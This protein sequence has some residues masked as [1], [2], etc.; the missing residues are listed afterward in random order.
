MDR[1]P[2]GGVPE[3]D[4]GQGWAKWVLLKTPLEWSIRASNSLLPCKP[5]N[6]ATSKLCALRSPPRSRINMHAS[7][8]TKGTFLSAR[9]G[10]DGPHQVQS[11]RTSSFSTSLA[12]TF[13]IGR[14]VQDMV[15][16]WLVEVGPGGHRLALRSRASNCTEL[17]VRTS[18]LSRMRLHGV[19]ARGAFPGSDRRRPAIGCGNRLLRQGPTATASSWSRSSRSTRKEFKKLL[20]PIAEHRQGRHQKSLP[21]HRRRQRTP[22]RRQGRSRQRDRASMSR[23]GASAV[24]NK[25]GRGL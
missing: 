3:I 7:E 6:S 12:T 4:G 13:S 5:V 20:M 2:G 21:P 15:I 25:E 23:R 1:D 24:S 22:V 9:V 19:G 11:P 18:G 17:T 16:D 10:S 8:L 14:L